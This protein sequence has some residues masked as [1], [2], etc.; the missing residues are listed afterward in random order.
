MSDFPADAIVVR[1]GLTT[2][3]W[4]LSM[5]YG[6]FSCPSLRKMFH[7]PDQFVAYKMLAR[8]EDKARIMK[9]PNGYIVYTN[10]Q[11][12]LT[13]S[14][15]FADN[16]VIVP[17]W[18]DDMEAVMEEATELKYTQSA[19]LADA[20]LRTGERPIFDVSRLDERFWCHADG[21]GQNVHGKILMRVRSRLAS[22]DLL[23]YVVHPSK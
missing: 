13:K 2:P 7:S 14:S 16:P 19:I 11:D 15:S 12:I 23:P 1:F 21:R 8:H 9:A 4:P 5:S 17:N 18:E 3:F 6:M 22:G 20:L 10:L